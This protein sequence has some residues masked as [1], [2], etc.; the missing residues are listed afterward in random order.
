M[1]DSLAQ[2]STSIDCG[3]RLRELPNLDAYDKWLKLS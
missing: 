2:K 1:P 3:G